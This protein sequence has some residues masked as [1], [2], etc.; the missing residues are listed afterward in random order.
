MDAAQ[1]LGFRVMLYVNIFGTSFNNE[2][3]TQM[4]PYQVKDPFTL[5]RKRWEY[6]AG[7]E[8]ISFAVIN[9]AAEAWRELFVNKMTALVNEVG[10]DALH[11]DQS[12]LM[13]NDANGLIDGNNMMQGNIALHREL[14]EALPDIALGGESLNEIT[15]RYESFAQ[16]HAYGIFSASGTWDDSKINQVVPASS[17][18]FLPRI[19]PFMVILIM[20]TRSRRIISW[21]GI[22]SFRTGSGP[23]R[24]SQ[25]LIW[26]RSPILPR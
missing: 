4:Q 26:A 8:Q 25:D 10:P 12:L 9:P 16:R 20:R 15:T 17:A 7:S 22:R 19:R 18:I 21:P 2:N 13:Y 3:Y 5:E 6:T 14:R 11:L 1:A 24:C 23:F